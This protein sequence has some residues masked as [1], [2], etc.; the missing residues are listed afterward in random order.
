[1]LLFY[2]HLELLVVIKYCGTL[3]EVFFSVYLTGKYLHFVAL[4]R[5]FFIIV[6]FIVLFK[7]ILHK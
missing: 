7:K 5:V 3:N 6:V 4:M 2:F 1:M